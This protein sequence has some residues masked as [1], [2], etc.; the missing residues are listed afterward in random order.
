MCHQTIF[1]FNCSHEHSTGIDRCPGASKHN[2]QHCDKLKADTL[3]GGQQCWECQA[4]AQGAVNDADEDEQIRRA[5]EAS[6][7]GMADLWIDD[8]DSL[9]YAIRASRIQAY[10]YD[11]L[12]YVT[13]EHLMAQVEEHNWKRR[14]T[15]HDQRREGQSHRRKSPTYR[16]APE[17]YDGPVRD[18]DDD[19]N[20]G[21]FGPYDGA[22]GRTSRGYDTKD[23]ILKGQ[24]S[25]QKPGLNHQ[26]PSA[27]EMRTKRLAHVSKGKGRVEQQS[28][29]AAPQ[30]QAQPHIYARNAPAQ[31]WA[32]HGNN[33]V[34]HHPGPSSSKPLPVNTQ[35]QQRQAPPQPTTPLPPQLRPETGKASIPS[36]PAATQAQSQPS[37]SDSKHSRSED[38]D[39]DE[40][41]DKDETLTAELP[42][43]NF[44]TKQTV[45]LTSVPNEPKEVDMTTEEKS[46]EE[47]EQEEEYVEE[48]LSPAELREKRLAAFMQDRS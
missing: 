8:E 9:V 10:G 46:E 42:F 28:S 5:L 15:I 39:E 44:D 14:E 13:E 23:G 27:E 41:E 3:E 47:E 25:G 32:P 29:N 1:R 36:R 6:K 19:D 34:S 17:D 2:L 43:P 33:H 4:Q 26:L 24:E 38:E 11:P 45:K 31:P 37:S 7:E 21:D 30:A 22:R 40:D 18:G 12:N 48:V 35:E 20:Q 16:F